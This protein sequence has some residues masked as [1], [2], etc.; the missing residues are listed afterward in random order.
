VSFGSARRTRMA[1]LVGTVSKSTW[2]R[3]ASCLTSS[4]TG[5]APSAPVPTT[6]RRQS[7]GMFS[8]IDTGVWPKVSRKGFYD[9]FLR[10]RT[11]P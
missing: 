11:R 7:Q 2:R 1:S 9:F 10:F 8:S 3:A 4:I 5:R 6:R